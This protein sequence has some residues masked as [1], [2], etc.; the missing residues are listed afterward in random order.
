MYI[1]L[2]S[3]VN[4]PLIFVHKLLILLEPNI[5]NAETTE[6]PNGNFKEI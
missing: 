5:P 3:R 1:L 4:K 6:G 2:D